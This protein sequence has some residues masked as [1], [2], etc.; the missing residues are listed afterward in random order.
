M[1]RKKGMTLAFADGDKADLPDDKSTV[2]V[3]NYLSG[4]AK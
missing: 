4:A 3:F 1:I 2:C